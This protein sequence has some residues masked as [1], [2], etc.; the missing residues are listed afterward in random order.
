MNAGLVIFL[1]A[2]AAGLCLFVAGIFVLYGLGWSLLAGAVSML[3]VAGFIRKG[4]VSG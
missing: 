4:L 1:I 2:A 3:A